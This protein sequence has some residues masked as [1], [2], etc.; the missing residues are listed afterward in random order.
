MS[1]VQ[2][3]AGRQVAGVPSAGR[4]AATWAKIGVASVGAGALFA[5]TG[6]ARVCHRTDTQQQ[7]NRLHVI[8]PVRFTREMQGALQRR[9]LPLGWAPQ[10]PLAAARSASLVLARPAA[11]SPA[12]SARQPAPLCSAAPLA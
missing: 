12:C 6:D 2:A 11:P 3:A 7:R 5:V 10:S 9:P 4:S 1:A 8:Q